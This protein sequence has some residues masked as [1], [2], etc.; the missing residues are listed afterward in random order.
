MPAPDGVKAVTLKFSSPIQLTANDFT[1]LLKR[2]LDWVGPYS[3]VGVGEAFLVTVAVSSLDIGKTME[4]ANRQGMFTGSTPRPGSRIKSEAE[5]EG[6]GGDTEMATKKAAKKKATSTGASKT[7][8]KAEYRAD[9]DYR[10][11]V[12]CGHFVLK[13]KWDKHLEKHPECKSQ[14]PKAK[15]VKAVKKAAK[16][17]KSSKTAK[18][19]QTA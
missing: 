6:E 2:E 12:S 18:K 1:K 16:K 14:T 13:A 4:L 10:E 19:E 11:C 3:V 5:S 7:R 8:S 15:K 17:A 9:P